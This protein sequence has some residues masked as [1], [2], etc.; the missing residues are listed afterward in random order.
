MF[1]ADGKYKRCFGPTQ[2]HGIYLQ[3]ERDGEYLYAARPILHEVLKIKTDGTIQL[4]KDRK[5]RK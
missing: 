1:G 5:R 3:R 4:E 2:I